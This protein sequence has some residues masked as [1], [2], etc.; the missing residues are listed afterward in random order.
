MV[1]QNNKNCSLEMLWRKYKTCDVHLKRTLTT[2]KRDDYSEY[3]PNDNPMCTA[4]CA[5]TKQKKNSLA[6]PPKKISQGSGP[7]P[8]CIQLLFVSSSFLFSASCLSWHK[9]PLQ[10]TWFQLS[11]TKP[12]L[13]THCLFCPLARGD[14]VWG[15]FLHDGS[16][17]SIETYI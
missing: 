16:I 6:E 17:G 7:S 4:K 5:Q 2:Q 3:S 11:N 13:Y 12:M 10:E 15:G 1:H 14:C 9:H 8:C